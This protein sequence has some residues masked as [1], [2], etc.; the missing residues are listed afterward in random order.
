MAPA[1]AAVILVGITNPEGNTML[2]LSYDGSADA[3]AAIDDAA[4]LMPGAETTVLTVWEPLMDALLRTGSMGA[5]VGMTGFAGD[6]TSADEE[7]GHAALARAREGAERAIALGLRAVPR[8]AVRDAGIADTILAEAAAVEAD[9]IV[10]GTRGRG[11]VTSFLLGSVSHAVVQHADR[12][13][14]VVPSSTLAVRRRGH[15]HPQ[16]ELTT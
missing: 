3:N 2:L 9:L 10:M 15:L 8:C 4:R 6:C 5:G 1:R 7:N 12:P 11:G 13:V 14:L 16:T